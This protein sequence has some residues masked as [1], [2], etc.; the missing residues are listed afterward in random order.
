MPRRVRV[1]RA[2]ATDAAAMME[3]HILCLNTVYAQHYTETA[4]SMWESLLHID[5]YI[6]KTETTGWCYV[7]ELESTEEV[8]GF[9]Y[10]NTNESLPPRIPEQ[11]NC[12]L[13]IDSLYINPQY[14]KCGVG[15]KL[16]QEIESKAVSEKCSNLWVLSSSVAVPFYQTLGYTS[17]VKD[18]WFDIH[19]NTYQKNE[20]SVNI[21]V[22]VK[23]LN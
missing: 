5:Y 12:V 19:S 6:A 2:I 9:G 1:R 16:L 8:I 3:A 22:L 23:K 10:L 7:A 14:Q 18:S 11:F 21:G 13:H 20:Y 17:I 15:K 4:L